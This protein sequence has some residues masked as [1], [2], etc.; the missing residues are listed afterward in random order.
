MLC[1]QS[2]LIHGTDK[3]NKMKNI[4]YTDSYVLGNEEVGI[5]VLSGWRIQEEPG[6]FD[7]YE[8]ARAMRDGYWE[9]HC[10]HGE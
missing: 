8:S 10:G 5:V 3:E 1:S 4:Y 9:K 6:L 7:S 2:L